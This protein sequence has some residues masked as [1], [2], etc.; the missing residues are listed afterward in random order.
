[1]RAAPE[2]LSQSSQSRGRRRDRRTTCFSSF[3]SRPGSTLSRLRASG[4]RSQR[5]Q[6]FP[7]SNERLDRISARGS[8]SSLAPSLSARNARPLSR[9][10]VLASDVRLVAKDAIDGAPLLDQAH[11][12]HLHSHAAT[13]AGRL[14]EFTAMAAPNRA[15][16]AAARTVHASEAVEDRRPNHD[17]PSGLDGG[18][19]NDRRRW[20]GFQLP[21]ES[22]RHLV[23]SS[24]IASEPGGRGQGPP[25]GASPR[26]AACDPGR[27]SW[28][29]C[30]RWR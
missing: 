15:S 30:R 5:L 6:G 26:A 11:D 29:A 12:P 27:P 20:R 22:P 14:R 3:N 25:A 7:S 4:K 13:T 19:S 8:R 17:R 28:T 10:R 1:M 21:N 2:L 18:D 23:R 9:E 24:G 16:C